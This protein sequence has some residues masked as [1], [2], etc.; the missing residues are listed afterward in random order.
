MPISEEAQIAMA[1]QKDFEFTY[2]HAK[3]VIDAITKLKM[4]TSNFL[5]PEII[6]GLEVGLKAAEEMRQMSTTHRAELYF[7][8][9]DESKRTG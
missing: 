5:I 4:S 1:I 8:T 3:I 6:N 9:Y 7:L 2:L